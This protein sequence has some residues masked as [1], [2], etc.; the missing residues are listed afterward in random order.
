VPRSGTGETRSD[1]VVGN[2]KK[3]TCTGGRLDDLGRAQSLNR[4][5][6]CRNGSYASINV[7]FLEEI[8]G[9]GRSGQLS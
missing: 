3:R 4:E 1:D 8:V 2:W 9:R 7:L 6:F 5:K